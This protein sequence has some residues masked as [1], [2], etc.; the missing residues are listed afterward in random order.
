MKLNSVKSD[1]L[2]KWSDNYET[3]VN[4]DPTSKKKDPFTPA[5][6]LRSHFAW[7]SNRA[8]QALWEAWMQVCKWAR[9]WSKVLSVGKQTWQQT[10]D[11]LCST[12]LKA[13][14]RRILIKLSKDKDHL[15]RALRN[16]SRAFTPKG[17][18]LA[19]SPPK[20]RDCHE[21]DISDRC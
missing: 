6:T 7:I 14:S 18:V 16:Q 10:T 4:S 12:R 2:Y 21:C 1:Q 11:G 17:E 13:K 20:L 8:L 19:R 9:T 15:R 3:K 5:S